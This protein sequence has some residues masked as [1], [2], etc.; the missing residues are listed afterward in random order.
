MGAQKDNINALKERERGIKV[1]KERA[2]KARARITRARI[3]I[4]KVDI[5]SL[6]KPLEK[7]FNHYSNHDYQDVWGEEQY[8]YRYDNSD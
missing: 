6:G 1:V 2:T 8:D 7:G 5:G 4:T 3:G